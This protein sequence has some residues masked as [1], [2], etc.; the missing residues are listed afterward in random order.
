MTARCGSTLLG[1][2][3]RLFSGAAAFDFLF[4]LVAAT[5][6]PSLVIRF[7]LRGDTPTRSAVTLTDTPAPLSALTA[8]L[9]ISSITPGLS[10]PPLPL[11]AGARR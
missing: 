7:T 10:P 1:L 4:V 6:A 3:T 5:A 9:A 11:R 2:P 8:C